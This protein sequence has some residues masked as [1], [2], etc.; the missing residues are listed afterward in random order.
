[1]SIP[2][3][4]NGATLPEIMPG[5][6]DYLKDTRNLSAQTVFHYGHDMI[7]FQ[8]YLAKD[9]GKEILEL[10]LGDVTQESID[11]FLQHLEERG[12][13][14]RSRKRRLAAIKS[15]IA[16]VNG[17][18][19]GQGALSFDFTGI[20]KEKVKEGDF[21]FVS[22]EQIDALLKAAR[23][24]S[25]W[26]QR[27]YAVLIMFAGCGARLAEVINLDVDDVDLEN[28]LICLGKDSR[29]E[30][31]IPLPAEAQE[32]LY[33]YLISR[34]DSSSRR[35]F[36]NCRQKPI[37]KGAIYHLMGKCLSTAALSDKKI[38][39]HMLRH[40]CFIN[41]A[42]GGASAQEIKRLAGLA[43]LKAAK[44]YIRQ[45]EAMKQVERRHP[46]KDKSK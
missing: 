30:R 32:A 44:Q 35:L 23:V 25:L 31:I 14:T 1:M 3:I 28:G 43:R 7:M 20:I 42:A 33:R 4:L 15:F 9:S 41:L 29:R 10:K 21:L 38:T 12:N 34:L 6:H 22:E 16:Y 37:T 39:I 26:P 40:T 2:P 27:D 8:R 13:C 18:A 24:Q 36:L 19:D 46:G 17:S 11:G 5:F 45:A